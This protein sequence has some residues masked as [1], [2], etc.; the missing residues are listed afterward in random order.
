[1]QYETDLKLRYGAGPQVTEAGVMGVE[2][3]SKPPGRNTGQSSLKRQGP[4]HKSEAGQR[5]RAARKRQVC[6]MSQEGERCQSEGRGQR[7]QKK[8]HHQKTPHRSQDG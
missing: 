4:G 2:T 7:T 3:E 6:E 8:G 5:Q 1:M